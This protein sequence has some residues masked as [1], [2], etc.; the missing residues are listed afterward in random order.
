M[1]NNDD[2]PI[3]PEPTTSTRE[4]AIIDCEAMLEMYIVVGD[5]ELDAAI[6]R[7]IV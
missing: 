7:S 2:A 5:E 6:A 1:E 4:A 3:T